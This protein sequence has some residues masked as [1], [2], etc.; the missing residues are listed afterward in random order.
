MIAKSDSRGM[1]R[2][3]SAIY[4]ACSREKCDFVNDGDEIYV[5]FESGY[6]LYFSRQALRS[7]SGTIHELL[8]SLNEEIRSKRGAPLSRLH[9]QT[10]MK[11]WTCENSMQTESLLILGLLCGCIEQRF[12]QN[13]P[14]YIACPIV[15]T[16]N[17]VQAIVRT[18]YEEVQPVYTETV[19]YRTTAICDHE[20]TS[21][22]GLFIGNAD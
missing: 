4:N 21:S 2:T 22:S 16:V 14:S 11:E 17:G 12:E 20:V 1:Q 5:Y 9:L 3:V 7:R 10:D 8:H 13:R 19:Y 6:P 15:E 18:E